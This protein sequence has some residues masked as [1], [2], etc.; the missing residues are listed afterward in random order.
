MSCHKHLN[1]GKFDKCKFLAVDLEPKLKVIQLS[2][3]F[4]FYSCLTKLYRQ[5][6][7]HSNVLLEALVL[8]LSQ[9][10]NLFSFHFLIPLRKLE[11]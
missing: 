2:C 10:P 9:F 4:I 5:F 3:C 11:I 8:S 6:T 7:S 1:L